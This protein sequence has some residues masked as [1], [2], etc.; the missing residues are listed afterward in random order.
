MSDALVTIEPSE[1]MEN[2]PRSTR[3][4]APR[5][6]IEVITR[7]AR[8]SWSLEQKRQIVSESL[9]PGARAG[10]I[11][12]KYGIG[13]GQLSMWRREFASPL[14]GE[15]AQAAARFAR[16]EIAGSPRQPERSL[17]R[18]RV[19]A[20]GLIEIVLPDG[21]LV[22]VDAKVD[23]RALRRVIEALQAR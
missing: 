22:R 14:Q 18:D 4:S 17:A 19:H 11:I 10:E 12:D 7:G 8:R 2:T 5:P 20:G 23:D 21:I 3:R 15:V 16:V 1:A 13:S 9:A 6:R